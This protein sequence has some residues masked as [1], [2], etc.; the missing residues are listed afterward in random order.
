MWGLKKLIQDISGT[1]DEDDSPDEKE[2]ELQEEDGRIKMI[3]MGCFSHT[4][5]RDGAKKGNTHLGSACL[6]I[7]PSQGLCG[8][9]I[10]DCLI[11]AILRPG[12]R[13]SSKLYTKC[14]LLLETC[15]LSYVT[16]I[17]LPLQKAR[18]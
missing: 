1:S 3:D 16:V 6:L 17:Y 14:M 9:H 2:N 15:L 8:G 7:V 5:E 4:P 11:L 13:V 18:C 10:Q 12:G